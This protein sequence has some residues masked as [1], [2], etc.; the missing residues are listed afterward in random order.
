MAPA[1][2][3]S[4]LLLPELL[5]KPT[6]DQAERE[7]VALAALLA[8]L[9]LRRVRSGYGVRGLRHEYRIFEIAEGLL[10]RGYSPADVTGI[11]GGNFQRALTGIWNA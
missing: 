7:L 3:G 2:I 5:T 10:R 9:D 1:G 6:R 4:M 11:L 8:R